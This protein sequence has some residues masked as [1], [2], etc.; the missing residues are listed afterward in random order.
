[1]RKDFFERHKILLIVMV[2]SF[3]T[4][5]SSSALTLSLPDIGRMYGAGPNLLSWVVESFVLSSLVFLLPIGRLADRYGKRVIFL[6]GNAAVGI[7]SFFCAFSTSIE[8][9]LFARI[10]QGI[11]AAML[12]VTGVSI[13]SVCYRGKTRGMAMGWMTGMVYAGL[14][15]GPVLGGF[16]NDTLGWQSIFYL[17]GV[18]SICVFLT[19]KALMKEPWLGKAGAKRDY[20]GAI[21]YGIAA[22]LFVYGLSELVQDPYAPLCIAAGIVFGIL[23]IRREWCAK[24]PMLSV[25]IFTVNKTFTCSSLASMMNYASTFAI[26]F[27]LSLYLQSVMGLRAGEA[28]FLLLVQAIVM[29]VFSPMTGKLS[30]KYP[31]SLLSSFGMALTT[32]G[33]FF[34][35]YETHN[36]EIYGLIPC[37][38]VIGLGFAFF[39]AP[40][41]NTIMSSVPEEYYSMASSVLATVRL[42]GQVMSIALVTLAVTIPWTGLGEMDI[43]R[44]N[45]TIALA[46]FGIVCGIGILPSRIR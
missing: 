6:F 17:V 30:D 25:R 36:S 4:P 32:I 20:L 45:I 40:N 37:L 23:F 1:M 28:G 7:T 43:L 14:A 29:S 24:E 12:Y 35:A 18:M 26:S 16:L 38:I 10:L 3:I 39:S 9:L 41:N 44:R 33:L 13:L 46:F 27:L 31:A 11:G 34:L 22:L 8:M 5:F 21:L 15:M 2:T 19:A 42:I